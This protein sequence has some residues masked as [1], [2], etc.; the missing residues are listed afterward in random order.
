MLFFEGRLSARAFGIRRLALVTPLPN[1]GDPG[2]AWVANLG[3]GPSGLEIVAGSGGSR[4]PVNFSY[5]EYSAAFVA[6]EIPPGDFALPGPRTAVAVMCTNYRGARA[7]AEIEPETGV[8]VLDSVALTL[9]GALAL[10]GVPTAAAR[11]PWAALHGASR[12]GGA[13]GCCTPLGYPGPAASSGGGDRAPD[14][15]G[16]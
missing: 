7:A 2:S 3:R 1:V 8:R 5:A 16:G 11:G 15:R 6:G 9:W 4:M 13:G 14:P 10:A 12:G